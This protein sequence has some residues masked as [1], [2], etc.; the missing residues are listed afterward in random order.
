[1]EV[2]LPKLYPWQKEVFTDVIADDGKQYTYVVKAKRQVGKSILAETVVLYCS[3]KR[4]CI[5]CVVEPT[6]SQCRR[7]YKQLIS[8]IGGEK[9]PVLKA[10]NATLLEIEFINGSQVVF[11]SAEQGEALRGL[12]VTKG[13]VLIIDEGAYIDKEI[14]DILLP[15]TDACKAPVMYLSTPLFCSGEFYEKYQLGIKGGS[16]VKSY[17]WAK[18]DTSELLDPEKLEYYRATMSALKFRSEI[19]GEFI[20]EGSYVFGDITKNYGELSKKP[21]VCGGLDWGSTGS[22]STTLILMDEDKRVW[23]IQVWKNLDSVDLVDTISAYLSKIPSIQTLVVETNSIGDVYL[24]MLKRKVRK[25]LIREFTTT[26]DSKR[27]A[28]ENLIKEFQTGRITI[29]QDKELTK[30]LQHYGIEKTPGGKVT[31]NGQN[32][33]HDDYV[34]AL[35][36][37]NDGARNIGKKTVVGFA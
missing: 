13:G 19:M 30:Q 22:D 14:Y 32:G 36:L 18:Y 12:T 37:A 31:Y 7:V 15:I 1:V 28:I 4:T 26:N 9:S 11:K 24:G 10:A 23:D 34:I 27:K 35:A 16:F 21:C 25:G 33:V 29:P 2:R 3:F 8:A 17:D 5:S 20:T 6:L